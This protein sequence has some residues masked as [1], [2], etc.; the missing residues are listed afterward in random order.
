MDNEEKPKDRSSDLLDSISIA[1]F[2][3]DGRIFRTVWHSLVR[4]PEV[5]QAA[6]AGDYTR[7]IAPIR[8]FVALFGFQ[9]VVASIFDIALTGSLEQLAS[10]L[11]PEQIQSWLAMGQMPDGSAVTIAAV[12]QS[13][14][15]W[16]SIFIWPV[17]ILAS[18]PFLLV[19]KLYRPS[20]PFWGHVQIYLTSSNASFFLLILMI[21]LISVSYAA[22][23]AGMA[24]GLLVYF[25]VMIWL[26]ARFYSHSTT[27]T[28]LRALGLI[29]L[30]PVTLAI[31]TTGQ[32][33]VMAW[34]LDHDFN[35]SF[36]E[37]MRLY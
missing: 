27:G 26:V 32:L 29:L 13:L 28:V 3:V 4:A 6:L 36:A 31:S 22:F 9:F 16:G 8:L 19:L 23:M 12:D 14:E 20:I 35:L 37:L 7:Y 24:F 25:V 30:L 10:S 11:T 1:A 17:T 2:D 34:S 5:A 18:L 15:E 21:P 33:L